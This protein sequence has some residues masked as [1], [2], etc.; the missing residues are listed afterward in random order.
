MVEAGAYSV[1]NYANKN[2]TPLVTQISRTNDLLI[3][4]SAKIA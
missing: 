4:A 1:F 3:L 2:M